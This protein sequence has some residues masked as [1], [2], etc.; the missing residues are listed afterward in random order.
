MDFPIFHL[1]LFGNRM[2]IAVIAILHVIINHGLAV[3]LAPII[4]AFEWYG[5]KT[6]QEKFDKLA[7]KLM[8]VAFV[9]TTTVGAL[10][11]VGI[12]FSVSLVNPYSI[13]SLI[14]VFFWAWFLEW[15]IFI[16]EVCL[17]LIYFLSWKNCKTE[18]QKKKHIMFGVALSVFSWI[19]MA[20]IVAILGF[21]MDPGNWMTE[22]SLFRA[23]FN[24]IYL[25]QLGFRTCLAI[26]ESSVILM[27]LS[28]LFTKKD[29]ILRKE[30]LRMLGLWMTFWAPLCLCFGYWYY[31]RIP[32]F[33]KENIP[34]ALLAT[35]FGTWQNQLLLIIQIT[36][37]AFLLIAQLLI[38]IPEKIPAS[39][40]FIPM[41][42]I[43]WL[44][45]HFE[46]VREFIRK[47]YIIGQY[48]YA[49]GMRVED[50]D[51]LNKDGMLA[52]SAFVHPL[53]DEEKQGVNEALFSKIQD[54]KDV[55]LIACSRCHTIKGPSSV[56]KKIDKLMNN[57]SWDKEGVSN[58][59]QTIHSIQQFMPPFP[60]N[61]YEAEAMTEYLLAIKNNNANIT[62][63]QNNG[64][65]KRIF[66]K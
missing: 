14:R 28:I 8:F 37:A 61:K 44:T 35:D 11:G 29:L 19:T 64:I 41:I 51:L 20:L 10:T 22:R 3:G 9:V 45:G 60:G 57:G 33:M 24:P 54:G 65:K 56:I 4:T 1:D 26:F 62:S 23:I 15:G 36:V 27:F 53:S 2:L 31:S 50:Y 39:L 7:Y 55:F 32:V 17:I 47:P 66:N 43:M 34:L 16:T 46:R 30:V 21:M 58:Y 52:H 25:P 5:F 42:L 18:A 59:I 49:N 38:L 12:W 13:S 6:K 63:A 48:M 40:A